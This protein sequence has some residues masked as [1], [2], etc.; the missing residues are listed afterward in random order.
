MD[1]KTLRYHVGAL[2]DELR[3]I[4]GLFVMILLMVGPIGL[5]I[6]DDKIGGPIAWTVL[7]VI[8]GVL[9]ALKANYHLEWIDQNLKVVP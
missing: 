2:G 6:F 3:A 9:T 7:A 8:I 5:G 4:E 1:E